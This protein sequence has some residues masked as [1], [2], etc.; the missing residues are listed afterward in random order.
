MGA[1]LGHGLLATFLN[2]LTSK[3][4]ALASLSMQG[5]PLEVGLTGLAALVLQPILKRV[6]PVNER[7]RKDQGLLR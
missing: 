5:L 7:S 6:S 1:D 2:W 3:D 4:A